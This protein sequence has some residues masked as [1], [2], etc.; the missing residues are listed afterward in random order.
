MK[1]EAKRSKRKSTP[2]LKPKTEQEYASQ[3][4]HEQPET[5]KQYTPVQVEQARLAREL[6]QYISEFQQKVLD[7]NFT[8]SDRE[9]ILLFNM[10]LH[11]RFRRF[12]EVA[13]M[14]CSTW[15]EA[16]AFAKLHCT[17][18]SVLMG[19]ER[20]D[21]DSMFT[22]PQ[23]KALLESGYF[24]SSNSPSASVYPGGKSIAHLLKS[25]SVDTMQPSTSTP[26][27][28]PPPIVSSSPP[29]PVTPSSPK[30]S[31]PPAPK[32][33]SP[34]SPPKPSLSSAS[35]HSSTSSATKQSTPSSTAKQ[36][37]SPKQPSSIA[38]KNTP[39]PTIKA[40]PTPQAK[41]RDGP[42]TALSLMDD[43]AGV[44]ID[45]LSSPK[46]DALQ[47][48]LPQVSTVKSNNSLSSQSSICYRVP[49]E[50][51]GVNLTFL[52]LEI[53]GKKVRGL[54]AKVR[55]GSSAM[56]LDC[57]ERLGLK[58]KSSNNFCIYTDFG[59]EDSIGIMKLPIIHP[60]DPNLRSD[61]EIQVLPK[62][63]NGHVDLVLGADFFFYFNPVLNIKTRAIH[64]LGKETPYIVSSIQI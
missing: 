36:A 29:K 40:Q 62:I 24:V 41:K 8:P 30:Q 13:E 57:V 32:Q 16:A 51:A 38:S 48:L 58:M 54:L 39:E 46:K 22:S 10:N 5:T 63:Y 53:N 26:K 7:L 17:R 47:R 31:S 64:F 19:C 56:S 37:T 35:K 1:K 45:M 14:S 9:L 11:P 50:H 4:Q 25:T 59:Y 2:S 27:Q 43:N 6:D 55:W 21:N 18:I 34:P 60:A 20:T 42:P 12:A 61:I 52:E 23:S 33:S 28:P 3:E 49:N 44:F 15:I